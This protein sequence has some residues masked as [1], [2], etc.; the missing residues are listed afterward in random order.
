MLLRNVGAGDIEKALEETNKV[1]NGNVRI[2]NARQ[3]GVKKLRYR[4]QLKV[5]DSHKE[6]HRLSQEHRDYSG[7]LI[8]KARRMAH[9]CWHVHGVFFDKLLEANP[10]AVI[11]VTGNQKIDKYGGNWMDRDIG[12][13]RFP[14]FFSNACECQKDED[15]MER[16]EGVM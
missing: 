13:I 15:L 1:F 4:F 12:S 8:S 11:V 2:Y 16:L 5:E 14:M 3:E 7:N 10:E 6:G 9:A